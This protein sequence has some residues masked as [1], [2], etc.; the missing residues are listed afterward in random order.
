MQK[1]PS[2]W[3]GPSAFSAKNRRAPALVARRPIE[4]PQVNPIGARF[5]VAFPTEVVM[6]PS[7]SRAWRLGLLLLLAVGYVAWHGQETA[8]YASTADDDDG[9]GGGGDDDDDDGKKGGGDD[10]DDDAVDKDQPPVTSG[11]LFTL[12]T[13]PINQIQR[14]LTITRN[15]GEVRVG[16]GTDISNDT[17]FESV[18]VAVEGVYGY[19]D[20]FMLLGGLTSL[21]NFNQFAIYG[22]FEGALAYDLLDFRLAGRISRQ[23]AIPDAMGNTPDQKI[24]VGVD[25]GFPFRFAAKPEIAIVALQT[26]MAIDFTGK[27]DLIPSAGIATNPIPQLNLFVFAQLRVLDFKFNAANII[28]PATARVS[29]SPNQKFDLGLEF[30]LL[31]L[32]ADDPFAARFLNLFLASR[33]G[34]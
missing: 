6:L 30:T 3:A 31:N 1:A 15:I 26:L 4:T 16:I 23:A 14:P 21:G 9:G 13:Y 33:F 34:K 24:D 25:I 10:D 28:V 19:S 17:A 29:F 2:G 12:K 27:P 22:G 11:G 20:N 18:G 8:V 32:K 7:L 5:G